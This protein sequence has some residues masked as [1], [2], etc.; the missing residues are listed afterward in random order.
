MFF[1][2]SRYE[3]IAEAECS[4]PDGR[5]IRYKRMRFIPRT[6]ATQRYVVRDGD[7]HDLVAAATLGDPERFW[8]LCDANGT[9]RPADLSD[10]PGK[11]TAVP[12]PGDF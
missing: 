4:A 2:G 8:Q 1:R 5:I 10:R 12:A 9:M 7:R 3:P 11:V 6:V